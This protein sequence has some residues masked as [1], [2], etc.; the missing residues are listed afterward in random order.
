M[1]KTATSNEKK[2]F[3]IKS[4]IG[5]PK[6]SKSIENY[7]NKFRKLKMGYN[8]D[9]NNYKSFTTILN[10]TK[11]KNKN[12][13]VNR[14]SLGKEHII[15]RENNYAIKYVNSYNI[16]NKGNLLHYNKINLTKEH[17]H[18]NSDIFEVISDIKVQSFNEYEEDA[19][20]PDQCFS[21]PAAGAV[22]FCGR[23]DCADRHVGIL[24][25]S[26]LEWTEGSGLYRF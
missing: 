4:E 23:A 12:I 21:V 8:T 11:T 1:P 19:W 9:N 26:R 5:S 14:N 18:K 7:K 16:K 10:K 24:Q 2:K 6:H 22:P 17:K 13:S 3:I 15:Q 25:L 20:L